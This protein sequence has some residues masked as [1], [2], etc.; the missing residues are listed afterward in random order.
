MSKKLTK[1]EKLNR[2]EDYFKILVR[3]HKSTVVK[4]VGMNLTIFILT[5]SLAVLNL[6]A[7][8]WNPSD[9][10]S[11]K[12]LFASVAILSAAAAFISSIMS[13][14]TFKRT[15]KDKKIKME[16]ILEQQKLHED[17]EGEYSAGDRDQ[18]L[19]DKVTEILTY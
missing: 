13:V 9:N 4:M 11:T 18:I 10:V 6:F 3:K 12:A 14:Y 16:K 7:L 8:R 2:V 5:A 19:V 17:H 1:D 15:S